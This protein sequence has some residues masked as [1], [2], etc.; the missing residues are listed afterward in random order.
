V[1][2]SAAASWAGVL[3]S[4][5]SRVAAIFWAGTA[6]AVLSVLPLAAWP[7]HSFIAL[8]ILAGVCAAAS[9][10]RVAA[11][12]RLPPWTLHVDV[13]GATVV[14]SL[15]AALGVDHHVDFDDLYIWVGLFTALYFRPLAVAAHIGGIGAAYAVVLALGPTDAGPVADW[16]AIFGTVTV[17]SAVVLAF[18]GV[19]RSAASYDPLTGLANRALFEG[20]L[21]RALVRR[22]TAG[23]S[24]ALLTMDLDGFKAVNYAYGH[25]AGDDLLCEVGCRLRSLVRGA[26]LV[27]RLG[28]DEFALVLE[29]VD[30]LA[31][32]EV[33][34][35]VIAAMAE[36]FTV[37]GV[38]IASG[39]SVGVH[40]AVP[41]E[42]A[43]DVMVNA[44]AAL[45]VAKTAGGGFE[46]FD[47]A[48][49]RQFIERYQ[50][51]LE[52]RAAHA[53]GELVL[54]YQPVVELATRRTV[55][56]EALIRWNH[57]IR[58]FLNPA[59]FIQIAEESGAIVEVGRWVICQACADARSWQDRIP[60]AE[61]VGVAVNVSRRQLRRP[62][63]VDDVSDALAA[64]GLAPASLTVEITETALMADTDEIVR[65]L[66]RFKALGVELALDDFGTGYSSLSQL[67][68]LPV[69]V[70]KIDKAFVDGIAREEEEWALATAIVRLAASLDKRTVAEGVEHASQLAH[71]RSLGC[72]LA[73]GYLFARPMPLADLERFLAS[74]PIRA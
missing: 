52:L 40:I 48:R 44:D 10:V 50:I 25:A 26:D 35:R 38:E 64:S 39:V 56:V 1:S 14:V 55:G 13:A 62:S 63:I 69:D 57:P 28:G 18:V 29:D 54:H 46:L 24:A 73:Q 32:L 66:D 17:A 53:R 58:G 68:A 11:S 61:H 43:E 7:R 37:A 31:V 42:V 3:P 22:R 67:R 9:G 19:L 23:R 45:Y 6:V 36:P 70:L 47:P 20:A 51:E 30:V 5:P 74:P 34:E 4:N 8:M 49:H 21:G 2:H 33:A 12:R 41:G 65:L 16:I 59:A 15:L 27:A 72:E 71:L 60:G